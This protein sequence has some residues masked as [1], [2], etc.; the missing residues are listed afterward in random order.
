MAT[1]RRDLDGLKAI[2][3]LAVI[4][5]H[6][7]FLTFGY[8]GV[9]LFFV[10]NG[11][12]ITAGLIRNVNDD[13]FSYR[14]FIVKRFCRLFPLVLIAGVASLLLGLIA[15]LPDNYENLAT[16]VVA[17]NFFSNNILSAITTKNYWDVVN[18][19]KPLM[20]TWYLGIIAEFYIVY[21]LIFLVI[22]K[23]CKNAEK[24]ATLKK[25]RNTV[26]VFTIISFVLYLIPSISYNSKFYFLPFRFFE[27]SA[28]GLLAFAVSKPGSKRTLKTTVS[29]VSVVLLVLLM[30]IN[31][32]F[33]S[34]QLRLISVVALS[35]AAVF[36]GGSENRISEAVLGNKFVS[37]LGAKSYSYFIWHQV[38]LAFW[39]DY[40]GGMTVWSTIICLAIIIV[41]SELSYYFIE[42]KIKPGVKLFIAC[43]VSAVAVSGVAGVIYLR[44]G[45][46]RN[47]PELSISL[48]NIT[49]NIHGQYCDRIYSYDK[50]FPEN[51]KLNVM[52]IGNSFARDW[53]NILLE[54]EMADKVNI[55][56]SFSMEE[57]IIP[58]IVESDYVFIFSS[59]ENHRNILIDLASEEK[60]WAIGTKNFGE[61]NDYFYLRRF[62][63]G[64]FDST[65]MP[66]SKTLS[67]NE[68]LKNLWGEKYIDMIAPVTTENGKVRIFTDD[69]KFISQDCRHLTK[70]GASFY[71]RALDLE[72]IFE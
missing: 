15:M 45:V 67:E 59:S 58:R 50:D 27:L 28:G 3:I 25:I 34:A 66:D 30:V 23:L 10:I 65:V 43:L 12:L 63:E 7:G 20:H 1:R 4:F 36:T 18:N 11:F 61:S 14:K 71:A 6:I 21:P 38:I 24:A 8:L 46:I 53:A 55:S 44:S 5:Y 56:Y 39:R 72:K 69:N 19:Y 17:S 42:K 16:S 47:V 33:M 22:A 40:I 60:V 29:C 68:K 26:L 35:L 32:D 70:D 62:S 13:S 48:D 41:V 64:Y 37:S 9:D 51:D 2:A 54:S 49:R 57:R 52:V 31:A